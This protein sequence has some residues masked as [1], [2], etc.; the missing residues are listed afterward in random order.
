MLID[1]KGPIHW[2]FHSITGDSVKNTSV[3]T[4]GAEQVFLIDLNKD[5]NIDILSVG[6]GNFCKNPPI[7]SNN[8]G[9]VWHKNMGDKSFISTYIF[10]NSYLRQFL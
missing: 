6:I 2:K 1:N 4:G 7:S 8:C 5:G 9:L 3:Q 10:E